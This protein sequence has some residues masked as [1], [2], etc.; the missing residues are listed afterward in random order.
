M[1]VTLREAL[2]ECRAKIES[3][4]G[5]KVALNYRPRTSELTNK[6]LQQIICEACGVTWQEV[7]SPSRLA[8]F[9]IA[10]HMFCYFSY[11]VQRRPLTSIAAVLNRDHTSVIHGRNKVAEM[12]E[13]KDTEYTSI[14]NEISQEISKLLIDEQGN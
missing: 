6:D 14:F 11:T 1:L 3:L 12:L 7:I 5:Y 9:V 8:H 2:D 10:R 4:V 13:T